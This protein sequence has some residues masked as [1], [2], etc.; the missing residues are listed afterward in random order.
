MKRLAILLG[1]SLFLVLEAAAGRVYT[2]TLELLQPT[3]VHQKQAVVITNLLNMYHYRKTSLNDSL[4]SVIFDRYIQSLDN[5]KL[6]FQKSDLDAFERYRYR[7]DD[8]LKRGNLEAPYVIYEIFKQRFLNRNEYVNQLLENGFDFTADEY[9]ESDRSK[10]EYPKSMAEWNETWRVYLKA[11]ALSLILAG[12]EYEDAKNVLSSRYRNIKRTI[13]QYRSEDVFQIYMNAFAEAYDPHTNYFSPV[14][15]ERF[16]QDMSLTFEGIGARLQAEDEYTKI[17]E[18]I[19]GGP[20]FKSKELQP[21]DRIIGVGQD[22]GKEITDVVGWRLDDV[23]ALIKGPKGTKVR[24]KILPGTGGINATPVQITLERDKIKLEDEAAKAEMLQ[25]KKNGKDYNIGVITI[26]SFYMDFEAASRGDADF[27]STTRDVRNLIKELEAQKADA[28]LIDLRRNGGGALLEAIQLTGLFIPS[29]PVV[30]T[31]MGQGQVRV[32]EDKDTDIAWDGPLGVLVDKFS[33]SASEIFAGAIQDYKRGVIIGESTFGKGSV[34]NIVDLEQ[35][36]PRESDKLGQIKL[37]FGMYYR[38]SGE[39]TQKRGVVPDVALPNLIDPSEYGESSRPNALPW[40]K[41]QPA[42]YKPVNKVTASSIKQLND[43]HKQR[44]QSDRELVNL[45]EEIEEA[46]KDAMN[47]KMSLNIEK[48]KEQIKAADQLR[49]ARSKLSGSI[50]QSEVRNVKDE[51][52]PIKDI[53]LKESIMILSEMASRK[54][55]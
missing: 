10:L 41:I 49:A 47:T 35:L 15:A 33:A 34:Q 42:N 25:V 11:Q 23:V 7:L 6:Y 32:E 31:K 14:N 43:F 51:E 28:I 26:P 5:G 19:P 17:V 22:D 27:R 2:D 46:K 38:V 50:N 24:L 21:N 18:I 12:R 8:D 36:L 13:T 9:Y 4:S 52:P 29:G 39:G 45:L 53:Y 55:G 1:L 3:E 16:R 44:L 48:R 37:T 20:A 54:I 30:Q 40:D